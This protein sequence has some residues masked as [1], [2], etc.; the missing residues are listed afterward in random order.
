[1]KYLT[2]IALLGSLSAIKLQRKQAS[3]VDKE[4]E[5]TEEKSGAE[6]LEKVGGLAED[7]KA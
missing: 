6:N 7:V 3:S 5:K 1:M 2:Y 4:S